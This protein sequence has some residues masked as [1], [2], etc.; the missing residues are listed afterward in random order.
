MERSYHL[1]NIF[2][3]TTCN[4]S[5]FIWCR[6]MQGSRT[7]PTWFHLPPWNSVGLPFPVIFIVSSLFP[8]LL[9]VNLATKMTA[10]NG[11]TLN[12][13]ASKQGKTLESPNI[14]E[15]DREATSARG[16][17]V[18][19]WTLQNWRTARQQVTMAQKGLGGQVMSGS[20]SH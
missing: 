6:R 8:F 4:Y 3:Q 19:T 13:P 14:R 2:K 12:S 9:C 5:S 15:S 11:K 20:Q 1:S 18:L 10:P 17:P 16:R 7:E